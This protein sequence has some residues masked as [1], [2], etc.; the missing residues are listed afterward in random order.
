MKILYSAGNRFGAGEELRRL[1]NDAPG[2]TLKTAAYASPSSNIAYVDWT[3][4]ALHNPA[5]SHDS[6]DLIYL[7]GHKGI[8]RI[9]VP[10][11]E[12]LLEEISNYGPDLIIC[13]GEPIVAHAA[14]TLN[15]KLWYASPL[16]LLNG[17]EWD[18][19]T[20]HYKA[21]LETTRKLLKRLPPS[22]ETFIVSPFGFFD[23]FKLKKG[24]K[25]LSPS[26]TKLGTS[27]IESLFIS[28]NPSRFNNLSKISNCLNVTVENFTPADAR[29]SELKASWYFTTGE[30]SFIF[31]GIRMSAGRL[32]IAPDLNDPE[33]LANAFLCHEVGL[34]DDLAQ[35]ELMDRYALYELERSQLRPKIALPKL[36]SWPTLKEWINQYASGKQR[37]K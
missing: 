28:S 7:F 12:L 6:Y 24:F 5:E 30:T 11:A 23:Q 19:P 2:V 36:K 15:I 37:L 26:V 13:D 14:Q 33:T 29:Y 9:S 10:A 27:E 4:D 3:L 16:H 17:I 8:P 18:F 21:L 35:L 20:C 32:A 31:D 34:G 22:E 25:W 1:L